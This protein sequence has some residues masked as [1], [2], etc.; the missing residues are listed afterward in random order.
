MVGMQQ[1]IA[2][3]ILEK[4]RLRLTGEDRKRL[5]RRYTDNSEAYNLYLKSRHFSGKR[6]EEGLRKSIDFINKPLT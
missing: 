1:E 5:T 2:N 3:E 6:S 4:L